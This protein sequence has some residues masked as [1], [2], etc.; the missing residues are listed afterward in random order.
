MI[1]IYIASAAGW[2]P[3]RRASLERLRKQ[4]P[5]AHVLISDEKEHSTI[6]ALRMYRKALAD[7][8]DQAFFLND[9]ITVPRNFLAICEALHEA[10]PNQVLSLA[11]V[12]PEAQ[13]ARGP[14]LRS[15]LLSGPAYAY[16]RDDLADLLKFHEALPVDL[17]AKMNED[18]V[19]AH[20]AWSR[21]KPIWQTIPSLALH[22]VEVPSTL[23]YDHHPRRVAEALW[24]GDPDGIASLEA[25]GYWRVDD[26]PPYVPHPWLPESVMRGTH[27]MLRGGDN[28]MLCVFCNERERLL[29]SPITGVGICNV[30]MGNILQHVALNMRVG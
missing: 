4:L 27:R 2:A 26:E 7:K 5:F 9:D 3:E 23:G 12:C 13:T 30:C 6:W 19:A 21:Q 17:R 22:D 18:E 15:Y 24:T 11:T 20:H 1:G 25:A 16:P 8:V 29:V 10:E 28:I 14:W